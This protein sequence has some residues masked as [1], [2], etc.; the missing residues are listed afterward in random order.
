M[1]D[2]LDPRAASGFTSAADYYARGRPC[3]P[4]AAGDVLVR[5][6]SLRSDSVVV[7]L[8]AGTG[9]V[10]RALRERVAAVVAVEPVAK[11]RAELARLLPEVRVLGG[12]AEA[13]PLAGESVDAVVVGEAFHWFDVA[14]AAE[15]IARV[16]RR[17]GGLGLLWNVATWTEQ[18]TPWLGRFRAL[19]A[20]HKQA[21]G[22]YPAGDSQWRTQL[23]RSECFAQL[24]HHTAEHRQHLQP[25]EFISHV[26]SWSWVANL[27]S[28]VR[29]RLVA[30]VGA[31]VHDEPEIT[32]PYRT[33]IYWTRRR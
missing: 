28:A 9:Q 7:D 15:E 29:E 31:L 23:E 21:A 4:E 1:G 12:V 22:D 20:H 27:R 16:L 26:R 32:I 17:G 6:L 14:L 2:V 18:D 24:D 8:A 30:E 10:A 19:V 3:Y 33:D 11:M 5:E 13:L 25:S